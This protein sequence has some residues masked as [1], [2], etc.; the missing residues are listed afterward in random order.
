[1]DFNK[2]LSICTQTA[3]NTPAN[4]KTTCILEFDF[5]KENEKKK[6]NG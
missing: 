1:M 4:I 6:N 5:E 3:F 2:A